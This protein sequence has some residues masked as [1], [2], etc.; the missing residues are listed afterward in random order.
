[1]HRPTRRHVLAAG[2]GAA[3]APLAGPAR[4]QW[5]PS[6]QMTIVVPWAPGGTTDILARVVAENLRAALGQNVLVENRAGASGNIGSDL[7]A[8]AAPDGHT[9][10]FGTMSTH[11]MNAA[12][13]SS[14]PF[15][16]VGDFTPLA[17]IGFA[18]NTMV[19]H[20]SVPAQNVAS[21]VEYVKASPGRIPY[22]SA[23][24]GS[25][26]HICAA[27]FERMTGTEM[28]H[29]PY[30][31]GAPA[32]TDTVGGRT[33]LFFTAATQ[34]LPHARA[35]RLRML[36]VTEGRRTPLL[37]DIP[38]V[39]ETVPG[40]EMAVWYGAF[41]PKGLAPEVAER[42]HAAIVGVM[43]LPEV[44]QRMADIGVEVLSE[45][46]ESFARDLRS[47]AEKWTRVIRELGIRG[48]G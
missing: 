42:L 21:F 5:A 11:V 7:V 48:E 27:L 26:N 43:Q 45:T 8:K 32:V 39:G 10:L 36:A 34:S 12:L 24:A 40:Y 15:D 29:V 18:T 37:P 1:M 13:L 4:A 46:R 22:A 35:G 31:G 17:K 47:E 30:R 2:L 3:A 41:G 16:G 19:V 20:P 23:G 33:Q 6:R 44:K 25:T 28:I 9:I 38:T 14:M